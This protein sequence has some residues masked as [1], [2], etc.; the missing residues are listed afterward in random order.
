MSKEKYLEVIEG[1][2]T[3]FDRGIDYKD[4]KQKLIDKYKAQ[5]KE[6]DN[7][8][9]SAYDRKCL[10]NKQLYCLV[11]MIQLCNGSRIL[12]ACKA[13]KIF[14]KKENTNEKIL[15]KIAKSECVKTD[16]NGDEYTTKPRFRKMRFP[17]GWIEFIQTPDLTN[18]LKKIKVKNLKQRVL[19]YLLKY[20]DCNT[21][22]LRYAF[23]NFMLYEKKIEMGLVSKFVGHSNTAQLV[24][25]SQN[26]RADE[27][28]DID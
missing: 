8:R 5:L 20:F 2:E 23:I 7:T 17:G 28:F 12:E 6:L 26:K 22:S 3:G 1:V 15:V 14:F 27:L 13:L 10:L 19:D 24:R 18:A 4:I 11:A 16:K 9:L 25:Y 21:H